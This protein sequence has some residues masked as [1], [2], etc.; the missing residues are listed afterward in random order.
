M[1]SVKRILCPF[2]FAE[3]SE[4]AL[5][6]A[7][8]FARRYS[9]RLE[10]LYVT[11]AFDAALDST[12]PPPTDGEVLPFASRA[13][14]VAEL[15]RAVE[16]AG[17]AG[18]DVRTLAQEGRPHEL[19]VNRAAAQPADLLVIGT[20]GGGFD[21]LLAGSVTEKVL[22]AVP[23]PVLAVPQTAAIAPAAFKKI[24]CPIDDS[25]AAARALREAVALGRETVGCVTVLHVVASES[26]EPDAGHAEN[27]RR[28]GLDRA[29]TWIHEQL[30]AEDRTGCAIEEVVAV[31]RVDQ[32]ILQRAAALP[33]DLIVMGAPGRSGLG[34][35]VH[36][37]T[38]QRVVR[39]AT[40]PVLAVR[41]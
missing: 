22:Q 3:A 33:A 27:Q 40:C 21:R 23:C 4:R 12:A 26:D 8:A 2:D 19:I 28:G 7:T 18:L 24:L 16:K 9:A 13:E 38:T 34:A 17:A 11:P 20:H 41:P 29:R 25:P 39:G 14:I 32:E 35:M 36:G 15:Q 10:V 31:N 30:A 37:S 6:Y 5:I 1:I